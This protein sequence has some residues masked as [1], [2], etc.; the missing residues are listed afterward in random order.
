MSQLVAFNMAAY[1]RAAGLSQQEL[2]DRLGG[3]SA[4]SVSAAERSWESKR[5]KVF[6]A[7]EVVQIANALGVPLIALF[8]P[9]ED[10]GTAVRYTIEFPGPRVRDLDYLLNIVLP[11][12]ERNSAAMGAY[13]KRLVTTGAGMELSDLAESM[14]QQRARQIVEKLRQEDRRLLQ[15][16]DAPHEAAR[17]IADAAARAEVLE[18]EAQARLNE[19]LGSLLQ[20]REELERQIDDLRTFEREYRTRLQTLLEGQLKELWEGVAGLQVAEAIDELRKRAERHRG[21]RVSGV[22]LREDGTYDVLQFGSAGE[23]DGRPQEAHPSAEEGSS[24]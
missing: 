22:L 7:D 6:D 17:I 1:R 18:R 3:W 16:T 13:L 2:G 5:T 15:E 19:M 11:M 23:S 24:S 20:R 4:A 10:H 14:A 21:Q 8:L 12:N 9:P